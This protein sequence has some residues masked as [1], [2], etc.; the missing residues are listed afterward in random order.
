MKPVFRGKELAAGLLCAAAAFAS[1]PRADEIV[2]LDPVHS[3]AY[4]IPQ[5][6]L[7]RADWRNAA[8]AAPKGLPLTA[9][10]A[11]RLRERIATQLAALKSTSRAVA[12]DPAPLAEALPGAGGQ[13]L[14]DFARSAPLALVARVE[15]VVAGWSPGLSRPASRVLLTLETAARDAGGRLRAGDPLSYLLPFGDFQLAGARLCLAPGAG[16]VVPQAG[17]RLLVVAYPDRINGGNLHP[18]GV[19][20][21][22]DGKVR[23]GAHRAL[24][25]QEPLPL[26]DLLPALDAGQRRED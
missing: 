24:A 23:P 19:F 3:Q 22:R 18:I 26:A 1:P 20:S 17:D 15:G 21:I 13:S 6:L 11:A 25:R 5:P 12:C 16:E 10:Q 9:E 2:W 7:E 4:L 8:K 14:A